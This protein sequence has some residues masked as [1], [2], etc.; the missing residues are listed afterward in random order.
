MKMIGVYRG[1]R[2]GGSRSGAGKGRDA[3]GGAAYGEHRSVGGGP[4]PLGTPLHPLEHWRQTGMLCALGFVPP[5]TQSP[6][7]ITR[8]RCREHKALSP[9][10][11]IR[12]TRLTGAC[13]AR[14]SAGLMCSGPA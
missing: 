5:F 3:V 4:L 1:M 12:H 2:C 13:V 7:T 9:E 14:W 10:N 6:G 8:C 11:I